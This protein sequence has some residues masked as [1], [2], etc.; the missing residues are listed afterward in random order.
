MMKKLLISLLLLLPTICEAQVH[1]F[2]PADVTKGIPCDKQRFRIAYD[3]SFVEDTLKRPY[4]TQKET[5]ILEIGTSVTAF[6]S[7]NTFHVDSIYSDDIAKKASQA[8][9]NE[10]LNQGGMGRIS[11]KLFTNY[12][13]KGVTTLLDGLS[14]ERYCCVEKAETPQWTVCPDSTA[15]L[16]GY[17]CHLATTYYKGRQWYAYYADDIPVHEGPWKLRGLP[18]LVL[19]AYDSQHQFAFEATG[20]QQIKSGADIIYRGEKFEPIERKALDKLYA[21]YYADPIG[22]ISN[23][24]SVKVTLTDEKG[25]TVAN[26][27]KNIPYN[28]LER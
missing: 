4:V 20:M 25:N 15:T 1:I 24:P 8:V 22:F 5:M 23:N 17:P 12:P 3:M 21:R 6:Y 16:L 19:R 18:G 13:K 14:M 2:T 10:H 26:N 11:W 9:I 27:P 28:P 7:Y